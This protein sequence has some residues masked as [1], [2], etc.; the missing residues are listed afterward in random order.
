MF[1]HNQIPGSLNPFNLKELAQQDKLV[2]C[3]H[4]CSPFLQV[5]RIADHFLS[6]EQISWLIC[7][8]NIT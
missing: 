1:G 6:E 3:Y 4:S 7:C 5:G 8:H 2:F